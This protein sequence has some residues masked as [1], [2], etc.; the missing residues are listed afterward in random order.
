MIRSHAETVIEAV[1]NSSRRVQ[2]L[3]ESTQGDG[4]GTAGAERFLAR[5][6]RRMAT[7]TTSTSSPA[8]AAMPTVA[9]PEDELDDDAEAVVMV[10]VDDAGWAHT[11]RPA[12]GTAIK[13]L[14]TSHASHVA[15][16]DGVNRPRGS[17]GIR[18]RRTKDHEVNRSLGEKKW[19]TARHKKPKQTDASTTKH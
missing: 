8:P 19:T 3:L 2:G 14:S 4:H 12:T 6:T 16:A 7:T 10:T 5:R 13:L 9:E 17:P 1:C 11:T 15:A 18:T